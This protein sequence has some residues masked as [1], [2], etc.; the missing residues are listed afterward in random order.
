MFHAMGFG[1]FGLFGLGFAGLTALS[2]IAGLAYPAFVI[3]MIVDGV[4]RTDAEYPGKSPN[5]KVFWVVI[6]VLVHP[7]AVAYFVMV[8]LKVKRGSMTV[9]S[10]G[11]MPSA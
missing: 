1:L 8:Y 3:W 6:M 10:Y 4:L 2:A 5:R 7:V 11:Q 9:P